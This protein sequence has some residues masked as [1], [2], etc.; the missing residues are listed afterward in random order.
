MGPD[1][2]PIHTSRMAA[3]FQHGDTAT[4]LSG[5]AGDALDVGEAI[6]EPLYHQ[7]HGAYLKKD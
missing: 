4:Y 6:E 2:G 1:L 5:G 3:I 7:P